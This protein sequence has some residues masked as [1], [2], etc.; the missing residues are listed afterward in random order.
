MRRAR[1]SIPTCTKPC[2][3]RRTPR[4][5]KATCCSN[6]VKVT[7]SGIGFCGLR[8]SSSPKSLPSDA[9]RNRRLNSRMA[10]RDYY[11][12]L[13]VGREAGEE[14]IKKAYRKLALKFHPD[15][16]PGDKVAEESF[17][18]VGEAYEILN[19]PQKRAAY[20]QYGHAAFDPRP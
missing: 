16:N 6:C 18:E 9:P 10:K 1:S 4:C 17:K 20:D 15:R 12:I 8:R 5:R 3:N 2:P 11:E 19:D 14:D 7:N 13:G